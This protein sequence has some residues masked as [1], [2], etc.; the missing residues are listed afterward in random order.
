MDKKIEV[1]LIHTEDELLGDVLGC[2]IRILDPLASVSDLMDA[3]DE[4]AARCLA[5]C[6]GCDGCCQE[7]APLLSPDIV[8]LAALLPQPPLWP[9]HAVVERFGRLSVQDGVS[10]IILRRDDDSVC[11]QLDRQSNCCTIWRRRPFVCRSH[12]C[13]PRSDFL[14]LLRQDIANL[15]IN[16]L[17]R[18]LLA[19]EAAGAPPLDGILLAD[20]LSADDYPL[21]CFSDKSDYHDILLKNCV[22]PDL[23]QKLCAE[24]KGS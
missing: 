17:T 1:I 18:L 22:S 3:L 24:R 13:L 11:A 20:R 19:E 6:K 12:F 5:D 9:A 4:F 15:G 21:N 2:D 16:E 8:P 10:D 7:R 14:E 23:W